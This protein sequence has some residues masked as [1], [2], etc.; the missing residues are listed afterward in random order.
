M[1]KCLNFLQATTFRP[2]LPHVTCVRAVIQNDQW[3]EPGIIP[4]GPVFLIPMDP[5]PTAGLRFS[6]D[7]GDNRLRVAIG[8]RLLVDG[9]SRALS[10]TARHM[11]AKSRHTLERRWAATAK[12]AVSLSL[13]SSG[14]DAIVE[15]TQYLVLP[16]HE[17]FADVVALLDLPLDLRFVVRDELFSWPNLGRYVEASQQISIA[18]SPTTSELRQFYRDIEIVLGEG[19][20][21]VIFPQGSV[22]GIEAAFG[23][24]AFRIAQR[25][26]IPVLPVVLAGSHR[27][28]DLPFSSTVRFGQTVLMQVLPPI[29]PE[30][31]DAG[32]YRDLERT[33]KH[34]AINES[35]VPV[36]RFVPERDG[37]WDDYNYEI[38]QDF[39][40]LHRR[41][42]E[43]R[44]M[45]PQQ[46]SP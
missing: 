37:W 9:A 31:L 43:R 35:D 8:S 24:G 45:T 29:A 38:D 33:M 26:N 30:A 39:A 21:I 19:D 44:L 6:S 25:F 2:T 41:V 7:T 10:A 27:V 32:S 22:L 3:A 46:E 34:I 14:V 16:L 18:D 36:R 17:G 15:D 40:D 5:T 20:S 4:P 12:R 42:A 1:S 13:N 28:C 11:N 23:A